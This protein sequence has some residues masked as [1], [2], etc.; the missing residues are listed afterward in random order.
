MVEESVPTEI[1]ELQR[2]FKRKKRLAWFGCSCLLLLPLLLWIGGCMM[3]RNPVGWEASAPPAPK[4]PVRVDL[5]KKHVYALASISPAR[6]HQNV[7]SLNQ[8]A[9][10]IRNDWKQNG[11]EV[12]EQSYQVKGKVYKNLILRYGPKQGA[13]VV[14]G[15]HYDVCGD[16]PGADDNATGIAGLLEIARLLKVLKPKFKSPL[17]L[18][19]YT[20]EEP[21]YFRTPNMG[22]ARHVKMLLERKVSIKAMLS[23]EMLGFFSDKP[24]SQNFPSSL[25]SL[26][27]PTKGSFISVVGN[28]K[29]KGRRLVRHIKR[30]M[31]SASSLPVYSINAP[32][33]IPGIDFSDHLNYWAEGI[34]AAM[35][36]D[37]SFFRNRNYHKKGDTP[38]SLDYKRMS[39]VVKGVFWALWK[40]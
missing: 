26:Y 11:F 29:T 34:P 5:L 40:L 14:V 18:V 3:L 2:R 33:W 17:E 36:T 25:L 9:S 32:S 35:V 23:L 15:A 6:N 7:P 8:A 1:E 28:Q 4:I 19:A 13:R 27:Y 30:Y 16:Q 10:Y 22:S 37:T 38:Q 39:E 20:L 31:R 24:N 21:P 12:F